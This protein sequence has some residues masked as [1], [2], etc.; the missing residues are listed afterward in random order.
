M[1]GHGH[2]PTPRFPSGLPP[3]HGL[4]LRDATLPHRTALP[5]VLRRRPCHA[6]RHAH[7]I[8]LPRD[9]LLAL[10]PAVEYAVGA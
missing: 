8:H 9:R 3:V 7:H 2:P 4:T 1:Y 10:P 5:E 6:A